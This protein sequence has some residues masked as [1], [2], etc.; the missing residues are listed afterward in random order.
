MNNLNEII[1]FLIL[2]CSTLRIP[3]SIEYIECTKMAIT[4]FLLFLLTTTL[5]RMFLCGVN[6]LITI[7]VALECFSSCTTILSRFTK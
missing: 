7:F 1:R 4:Q 5:R 2:L 3:L 6:D